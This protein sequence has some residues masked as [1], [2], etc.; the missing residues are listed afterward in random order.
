MIRVF[1]KSD[2]GLTP[3][4]NEANVRVATYNILSQLLV[5]ASSYHSCNP[6]DLDDNIRY[7]RITSKIVSTI[8][9]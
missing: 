6:E 5:N 4:V 3:E 2:D 9:F 8:R 7:R 1:E